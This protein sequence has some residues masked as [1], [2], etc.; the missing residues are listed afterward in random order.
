MISDHL[1][2]YLNF[3]CQP[4]SNFARAVQRPLAMNF[5]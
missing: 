1:G 3:Y 5:Q 2:T 4:V